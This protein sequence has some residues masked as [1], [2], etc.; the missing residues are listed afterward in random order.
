MEVDEHSVSAFDDAPL[1]TLCRQVTDAVIDDL[2]IIKPDGSL[3]IS[4]LSRT[5]NTSKQEIRG[6]L[7]R[8][9]FHLKDY[10]NE[11]L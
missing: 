5:L 9:K 10:D 11:N 4:K 6:A 3:N 1:D 2:R 8:L 7:S